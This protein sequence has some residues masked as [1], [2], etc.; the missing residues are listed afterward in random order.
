M[1]GS[2]YKTARTRAAPIGI[3]MPTKSS[4]RWIADGKNMVKQFKAAG[5][6]TDLQYGEDDV[7]AARSPRSRT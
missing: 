7:D 5:Y 2:R 1:G 6:K 4:E 3:A